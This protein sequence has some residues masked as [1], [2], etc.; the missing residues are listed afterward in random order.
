MIEMVCMSVILLFMTFIDYESNKKLDNILRE[1]RKC[2][3][4][5]E[6]KE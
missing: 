3:I 2:G 5:Q 6:T 4:H 1:V